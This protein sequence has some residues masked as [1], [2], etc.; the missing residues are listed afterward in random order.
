LKRSAG[1]PVPYSTNDGSQEGWVLIHPGVQRRGATKKNVIAMVTALT[2][3]RRHQEFGNGCA[4]TTH[5]D[6]NTIQGQGENEDVVLL[7]RSPSSPFLTTPDTTPS[8]FTVAVVLIYQQME[9]KPNIRRCITPT[10]TLVV[11]TATQ[12]TLI[13]GLITNVGA[14]NFATLP[15]DVAAILAER[16]LDRY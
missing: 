9:W 4:E 7:S 6:S 2:A 13:R 11:L 3:A 12:T 1:N 10:S 16:C 15:Q 8:S 5:F 14:L